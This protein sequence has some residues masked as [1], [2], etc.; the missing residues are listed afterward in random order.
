[1]G[2]HPISNAEGAHVVAVAATRTISGVV[3]AADVGGRLAF[4]VW[5]IAVVAT[6]APLVSRPGGSGRPNSLCPVGGVV[7]P[8]K[9]PART[10]A[11]VTGLSV[12]QVLAAGKAGIRIRV[13]AMVAVELDPEAPFI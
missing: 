9:T 5:G 8:I 11:G 1:M 10:V 13:V 12:C 7:D 6:H 2:T 3:I 4:D